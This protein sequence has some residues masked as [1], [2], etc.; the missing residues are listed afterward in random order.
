[1]ELAHPLLCHLSTSCSPCPSGSRARKPLTNPSPLSEI[2]TTP[3]DTILPRAA[4]I[5]SAAL[6]AL[7]VASVVC[8]CQRSLAWVSAG[9]GLP[10]LG[11]R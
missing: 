10:F 6:A 2:S 7:V 4:R 9:A 3:G 5:L 8:Q 11:A 1:M